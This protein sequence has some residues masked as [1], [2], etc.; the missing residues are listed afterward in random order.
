MHR[1][2]L[3]DCGEGTLGALQRTLG[4]VEAKAIIAGL[5][6][7]FVSHSHADH[8][9]GL[10]GLL[11]A[12]GQHLKPLVLVL[13]QPVLAW[14]EEAHAHLL[15][16]ACCV[17]SASFAGGS[18]IAAVQG[19][20]N[21][22]VSHAASAALVE[23]GFVAWACPRVRHCYQAFGVVLQHKHGWKV[24]FSGD[25]MPSSELVR[26]GTGASL[27]VHEATFDDDLSEDAWRKR[28]STISEALEVA[29]SM[30]AWRVVLT[31]FSQRYSRHV[32]NVWEHKRVRSN[33]ALSA[34][35]R[36]APA[37]DGM[38]LPFA[39]LYTLPA[40]AR[41]MMPF[42]TEGAIETMHEEDIL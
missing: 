26:L 41:A 39:R 4:A 18:L 8:C 28:H 5:V 13:P 6:A 10:P 34:L 30:H 22:V 36:A 38:V 12:R 17:L 21:S 31:H 2:V 11:Q 27:L 42:V 1:F 14:L 32:P 20:Q 24:V 9:L 40:L 37:F 29:Q 16:H 15:A 35:A 33:S 3:L 7:V 19:S 25:T 23:A